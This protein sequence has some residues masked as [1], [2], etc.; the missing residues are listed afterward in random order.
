MS[1]WNYFIAGILLV[2]GLDAGW[3]IIQLHRRLSELEHW[4]R[5]I[6]GNA[7][8]G[9]KHLA[10]NTRAGLEHEALLVVEHIE[11]LKASLARA[12]TILDGLKVIRN[13][14]FD[15][16]KPE[17]DYAKKEEQL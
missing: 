14:K 6:N 2:I 15:P 8:R 13:C 4:R 11:D 3:L 10:W 7:K 9:P 1:E 17:R 12:E 16:D 5:E